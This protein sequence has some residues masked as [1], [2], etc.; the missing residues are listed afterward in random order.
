MKGEK[1]ENDRREREEEGRWT[2]DER[3]KEKSS[4]IGDRKSEIGGKQLQIKSAKD[5]QVYQKAY[6]LA[7]EIFHFSKSW[8]QAEKY[9]LTDQIRRSSRAVPA[10]IAEAW[11]EGVILN[12]LLVN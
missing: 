6:D 4:E 12:H 10:I 11:Q 1:T 9:S 5:L 7:M 8:P 2:T 3:T